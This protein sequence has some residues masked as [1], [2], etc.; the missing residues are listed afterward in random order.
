MMFLGGLGVWGYVAALGIGAVVATGATYEV[1][2]NANA[3]EISQLK[4]DAANTRAAS[5]TAALNQLTGFIDQMHTA[6]N[7][8]AG[9]LQL[10]DNRFALIQKGLANARRTPLPTDCK[11]DAGRVRS[12]TDAIAAANGST[13]ADGGPSDPVPTDPKAKRR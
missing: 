5:A 11:P 2:H 12:L 3:V 4:T 8:Y 1:V 7:D 13:A 6:S 9:Q 10:I